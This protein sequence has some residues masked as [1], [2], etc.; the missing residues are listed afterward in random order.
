M[1]E[2]SKDT[3]KLGAI[4]K[5]RNA[6][7]PEIPGMLSDTLSST[8]RVTSRSRVTMM[9]G[10]IS[11]LQKVP[12]RKII[13]GK[14]SIVPSQLSMDTFKKMD[15]E[16][17]EIELGLLY[18]EY[19]QTIMLDLIMKKK[20]EEKRQ[21]LVTQLATVAQEIDQDTKK[22]IKIKTRERDIINL[23]LAQKE[24]DAQ[25]IIITKCINETLKIVKDML[26]KLQSLLEPLDILRCNDIILPETKE[27]WQEVLEV[28]KNCS[29]ALKD[30]VNLIQSKGETY[31]AVNTE[32]KNFAETYDKIE[33]LQKE[34]EESLCK[35]QVMILK[36]ASLSLTYNRI[37]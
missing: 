2:E 11:Q 8:S 18:D 5:I 14:Q 35:I 30:I 32:L 22:L 24:V 1:Q 4:R 25:L 12:K 29:N 15:V 13:V 20:T 9:P 27:E 10:D 19:L 31:C 28:L 23:S 17:K 34:L 3:P 21:L 16:S 33:N 6:N 37:E 36:N 7:T 26:S